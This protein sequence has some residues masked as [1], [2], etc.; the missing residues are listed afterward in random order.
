MDRI[1]KAL[2]SF[3]PLYPSRFYCGHVNN[4]RPLL[5]LIHMYFTPYLF[6]SYSAYDYCLRFE[7]QCS[8][9]LD[10]TWSNVCCGLPMINIIEHYIDLQSSLCTLCFCITVISLFLFVYAIIGQCFK[11][12][13][14]YCQ[15]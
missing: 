15:V 14:I 6:Y 1:S 5:H 8:W 10:F 3:T 7:K 9:I 12:L 11:V 2:Y 13:V 4:F